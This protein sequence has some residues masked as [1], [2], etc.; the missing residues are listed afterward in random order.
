MKT[1]EAKDR[2]CEYYKNLLKEEYDNVNEA[3]KAYGETISEVLH[4]LMPY[5][6]ENNFWWEEKSA[7]M[8]FYQLKTNVLVVKFEDFKKYYKKLT[9]K[10]LDLGDLQDYECLKKISKLAAKKFEKKR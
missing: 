1:E 5:A 9:G 4:H 2:I 8:A 6:L 3:S 10:K 7:K